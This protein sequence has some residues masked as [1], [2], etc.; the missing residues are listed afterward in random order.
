M[1]IE[2]LRKEIRELTSKLSGMSKDNPEYAA[3]RIKLQMMKKARAHWK[4]FMR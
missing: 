4:K 2:Q 1:K 3:L